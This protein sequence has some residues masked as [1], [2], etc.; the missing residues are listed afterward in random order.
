MRSPLSTPRWGSCRA[1][2][3]SSDGAAVRSK[4]CVL[5]APHGSREDRRGV[6]Q[7]HQA[8]GLPPRARR[9]AGAV[10]P[11]RCA[12]RRQRQRSCARTVMLDDPTEVVALAAH[13]DFAVA[14]TSDHFIPLLYLAGLAGDASRTADVLVDGA[15]VHDRRPRPRGHQC[16]TPRVDQRRCR[17]CGAAARSVWGR[18]RRGV[19]RAG[20]TD[21]SRVQGRARLLAGRLSVARAAAVRRPDAACPAPTRCSKTPEQ[22]VNN[23]DSAIKPS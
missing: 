4:P 13:P 16:L 19:P 7:R 11:A 2:S 22:S 20:R 21:G 1:R 18:N 23:S 10:A 12:G 15:L 8:L 9:A 3:R 14:P 6:H 5:I 17:R